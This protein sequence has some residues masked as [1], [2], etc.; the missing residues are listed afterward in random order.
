MEP[1]M[2][3][4]QLIF[5]LCSLMLRYP[6]QEWVMNHDVK[7]IVNAIENKE[8][9]TSLMQFWDYTSKTD[10]DK[11]TE[12]YV[13]WFDLSESKTM[14]LTYNIFGDNRER[15]QAFV[16]LKMEFAKAGFYIKENE[17][18]DYLPL[19]LEFASIAEYKHAQKVIA[20]HYKAIMS[21]FE[22]LKKDDLPYAHLVH[23][24][25][26]VMEKMLPRTEREINHN[27]G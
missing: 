2:D 20:I 6:D 14:Y 21:L 10:W 12:N 11:L 18:P 9:K 22:E 16:K 17:L 15:G 3:D 26:C 25:L 5:K 4:N 1:W 8:I 19:I 27:A 13:Q 24:C 7:E 23:A